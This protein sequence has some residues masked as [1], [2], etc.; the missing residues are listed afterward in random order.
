MSL[1]V[2]TTSILLFGVRLSARWA[3]GTGY[4]PPCPAMLVDS[5]SNAATNFSL[6]PSV[7]RGETMLT[8]DQIFAHYQ[9]CDGTDV[10]LDHNTEVRLTEYKNQA[11]NTTS[12][13]T[14]IQG[15]VLV[16]GEARVQTRN[17]VTHITGS[18]E[19]VHYSW[20]DQADV[21][22]LKS[23][24]CQLASGQAAENGYTSRL[25][26]FD[27][28]LVSSTPFKPQISTAKAWYDWINL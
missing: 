27:N 17:L 7:K 8:N 13:L 18:C 12:T 20:L 26:T 5:N 14:L 15:R 19:V 24:Q 4:V 21:T 1:I 22:P 23:G 9:L 28:T 25:N 6:L 2:G 3:G 10:Y 11:T 16:S